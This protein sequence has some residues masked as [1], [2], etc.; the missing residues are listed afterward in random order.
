MKKDYWI[1]LLF[2]ITKFVLQYSLI[3][4]EYELHR[5]EY[6]HLNQANH[7][8]W[9]YLSVPP[10]NS[11]LAWMIKILGNSIFWVKFF[12]A[13]FG[14]LTMALTWKAVEE[15]KGNLF[16]KVLASSGIL[17]SVLLR[18]NMLFQPTSLEIFLW[19]FLYYSLIKYFNSQQVKWLYIGAVIFGT[20]MLNKYNIAFSVLGLIPALLLTKQRQVFMQS[21][22]Y[23]AAL[24]ALI[25]I[26]PN[27]LWQYQNRFPVIHHMK[28]LSE[29]QL[30]HIDRM[31]FMKSQVLFF[32]GAVFVIIAGWGALLLYKPFEKFRFFF[33]AYFITIALFLVF[34]AKDYYAIGLYPVY[35]AFGSV[36]LGHIFENGW[37]RFLKP[38]SILI[39]V[40]LFLPLYNVAFPN[41][42]PEYIV[43]HRDQYKKFG[44]LRWEDGKD[45][46]LPQDFADMQGWK[47]LT[48]KVDKE[49][50][51]LSKSGN[52]MVLCDNYGQAGAINYYS[53]A[54]V[55]AMSF[56]ADYINWIDLSRKY[57]NIIRIKNASEAGGELKESGS[58]FEIAKLQDSIANPYARERGT[59]IFSLQGAKIDVNKRIQD[60]I[61]EVKEEK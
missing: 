43:S 19:L 10:V 16:A 60:E 56:H 13:L 4:P 51:R 20:G 47:E 2:I 17:F 3:S 33:W 21:H 55:V 52:T 53:K 6:L 11:W 30:V 41:K 49:Y 22:V 45:H 12:P 42:N 48:A 57:K 40:V 32:I 59:A 54:G 23:W 29:K 5:D 34:K 1:L 31:D 50:S 9:G 36:F 35:I 28:E 37:K 18:V 27:L 61:I 15:L 24:L 26:F 58:F 46:P 44:L 8:A 14:A 7:L 25:I 39:P 38:V